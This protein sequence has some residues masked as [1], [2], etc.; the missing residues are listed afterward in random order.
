LKIVDNNGVYVYSNVVP[1]TISGTD[2]K[3]EIKVYPTP[4]VSNLNVEINSVSIQSANIRLF[5]LE[6]KLVY[7][8]SKQLSKGINIVN[9][10]GL[11]SL[12]SATYFIEVK[13][14]NSSYIK[15]VI[16]QIK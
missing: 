13:T 1:L 7:Q 5:T 6:G 4:F 15:K 14:A 9:L 16:K 3:D 12:Q 10:Q 2:I 11:N 8:L